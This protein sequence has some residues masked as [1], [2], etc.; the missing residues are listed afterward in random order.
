MDPLILTC[1]NRLRKSPVAILYRDTGRAIL[2]NLVHSSILS[3]Q[4]V[5]PRI[6]VFLLR[7]NDMVFLQPRS[8]A[9]SLGMPV[10]PDGR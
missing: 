9:H 10:Q 8:L 1:I 3:E 4:A 2:P 7:Q 6:L 5:L